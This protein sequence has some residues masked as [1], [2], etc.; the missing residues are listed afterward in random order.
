MRLIIFFLGL[1]IFLIGGFWL[2]NRET[3]E[4]VV[5]PA[6]SVSKP[7]LTASLIEAKSEKNII[8]KP[9]NFVYQGEVLKIIIEKP[10]ASELIFQDKKIPLFS[11][12]GKMIGLI[13]IPFDAKTGPTFLKIGNKEVNFEILERIWPEFPIPSPKPLSPRLAVRR[14]IE[15]QNLDEIMAISAPSIYFNSSFIKPLTSISINAVFG[16]KRVA[17]NHLSIHNGVDLKA[18]NGTPVFAV[19]DGKVL[20]AE[21]YLYEGG[22]V[23]I[24]HGLNIQSVYLHLSKLKTKTGQL[25]KKGDLIGLAG[26]TGV[27]EGPHLHFE[28]KINGLAVDPLRFLELWE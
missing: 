1:I 4:I 21:N 6:M 14:Q 8:L 23:I 9:S 7:T 12:Q 2:F 3:S 28:I 11:Y 20:I 10:L 24:D 15:R 25:V 27:A 5:L 16:E 19:N 13:P 18:D 17:Q 26:G 22:F